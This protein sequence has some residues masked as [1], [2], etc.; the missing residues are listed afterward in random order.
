MIVCATCGRENPGHFRF[1]LG[2]GEQL[3]PPAPAPRATPPPVAPPIATPVAPPI[4]TPIATPVAPPVAATAD[5]A[6]PQ[7]GSH[8]PPDNLFCASCG[9]KIL[10]GTM[11]GHKS[12]PVTPRSSRP[13]PPK[14][15]ASGLELM[16]LRPDGS[17]GCALALSVAGTGVGRDSAGAFVTDSYLSPRHASFTATGDRVKVKD[18][19]SLNGIFRRL[20]PKQPY[21]IEL[22][23]VFRIGQEL[24]RFEALA[25]KPPDEF[26]VEYLGAPADGYVGRIVMVLGRQSTGTAFPVPETGLQLGRES[27]EVL[28]ADDGYVSSSHCRLSCDGGKVYLTDMGSS[29]GTFVRIRDEIDVEVGQVLLMGQQ[30][31]RVTL[32]AGARGARGA[33]L[34]ANPAP[35]QLP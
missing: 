24:I 17:D 8:N 14:P 21:P 27:G 18:D 23:Q 22:G 31:Y 35:R 30:L 11:V 2:C 33:S 16:Q 28:F 6:C 29:N 7:C 19:G 13:A 26:G 25:H 3:A 15:A 20:A 1:C 12:P 34:P 4:A 9:A 10:A 5:E 32:A